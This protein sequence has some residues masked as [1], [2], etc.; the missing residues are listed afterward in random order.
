ME[1]TETTAESF[2]YAVDLCK[3]YWVIDDLGCGV[4]RYCN[5]K[6]IFPRT[7]VRYIDWSVFKRRNR[8]ELESDE[9]L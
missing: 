7:V 5:E 2:N 4:C 8:F 6:K 9:H 1:K 3:H